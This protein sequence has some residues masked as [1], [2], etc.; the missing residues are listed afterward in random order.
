MSNSK[1]GDSLEYTHHFLDVREFLLVILVEGA[2]VSLHSMEPLLESI[3]FL[4]P[5][6]KDDDQEILIG[7]PFCQ[8]TIVDCASPVESSP[9][10]PLY[11]RMKAEPSVGHDVRSLHSSCRSSGVPSR[12]LLWW[13]SNA[14]H[15]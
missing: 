15:I 3:I 8:L 13:P 12:A 6:R 14:S 4:E 11:S 5:S 2:M 9:P 1:T 7:D 10:Q